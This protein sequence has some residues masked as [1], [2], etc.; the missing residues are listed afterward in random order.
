[1][2]ETMNENLNSKAACKAAIDSAFLAAAAESA[3]RSD[4]VHKVFESRGGSEIV[5]K[6][7]DLCA[8]LASMVNAA[9]RGDD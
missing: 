7:A 8:E 5:W 6:I 9:L 2:T 3:F 1:M 4:A